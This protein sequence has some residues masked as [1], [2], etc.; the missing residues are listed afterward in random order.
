MS[1]ADDKFEIL[2]ATSIY[3]HSIDQNKWEWTETIL[4][5]TV[6]LDYSTMIQKPPIQLEKKEIVYETWKPFLE[7]LHTS[8]HMLATP[9]IEFPKENEAVCWA[10]IQAQ[11]VADP[12]E[13]QKWLVGARYKFDFKKESKWL[14]TGIQINYIWSEGSLPDEYYLPI[15]QKFKDS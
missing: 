15:I 7:Q 1:R 2:E 12:E 10:Y 8:Q 6:T 3:A 4:A 9:I 13:K 5:D 11:H 14:I